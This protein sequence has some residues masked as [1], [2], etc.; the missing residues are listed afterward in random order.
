MTFASPKNF[1]GTW[2]EPEKP[3]IMAGMGT[4]L[5]PWRAVTQDR[6]QAASHISIFRNFPPK[7]THFNPD[8]KI[9]EVFFLKYDKYGATA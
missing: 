3:V 7:N 4:G 8:P 2:Q 9:S 5:A 6:L 1:R